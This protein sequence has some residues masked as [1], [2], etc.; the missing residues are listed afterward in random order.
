M[1]PKPARYLVLLLCLLSLIFV[2][3]NNGRYNVLLIS[4]DTLRSDHLGCYGYSTATPSIDSFANRS[5]LFETAISQVPLTLPSHCTILTGLY[6]DQHGVRNNE[7]FVLPSSITTL[8][9]RFREAGYATGAVVGSFSLDSRFGVNQG[10]QYYEDKIGSS[11]D[12]EKNRMPSARRKP[13]GI[14]A[15]PGSTN[16][17]RPGFAFCTFSIR[18]P[19]MHLHG[20]IPRLMMERSLIPIMSLG[21]S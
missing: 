7:S 8:A 6:P 1:T 13:F 16:R 15:A 14:W 11:H 3:A 20:H 2:S 5:V 10:F 17:S 4:I 19:L 12:A 21:R 18:T 9:E